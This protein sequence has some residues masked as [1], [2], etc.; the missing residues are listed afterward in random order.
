MRP[1]RLTTTDGKFDIAVYD[2]TYR[3][4]SVIRSSTETA[5]AIDM[6]TGSSSSSVPVLRKPQ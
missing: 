3:M 4:F 6:T 1:C 2:P 5:L